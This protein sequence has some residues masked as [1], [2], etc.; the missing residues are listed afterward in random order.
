MSLFESEMFGHVKGAFTDAR[1]DRVGRFEM[2][3]KGTIFLDE[4]GDLDPGKPGE[5]AQ[6]FAGQNLRSAGKQPHENG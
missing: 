6:G 1:F 2:A 3:N 4:I 5:T